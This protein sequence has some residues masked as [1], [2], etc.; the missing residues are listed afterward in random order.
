MKIKKWLF[1]KKE[2]ED[3]I[4]ETDTESKNLIDVN[5]V[6]VYVSGDFVG[7]Y[8]EKTEEEIRKFIY[9]NSMVKIDGQNRTFI[10]KSDLVGKIMVVEKTI[11]E[12]D[13]DENSYEV[14]QGA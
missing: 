1:G 9:H 13:F 6:E 2:A 10:M 8:T 11:S 14:I 4:N 12:K 7:F 3:S 5:Y